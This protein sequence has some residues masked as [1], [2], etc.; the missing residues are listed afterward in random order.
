MLDEGTDAFAE[1]EDKIVREGGWS[2]FITRSK[3]MRSRP[4]NLRTI[5]YWLVTAG[6]QMQW[7]ILSH[8]TVILG[9]SKM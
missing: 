2:L 9:F 6:S 4:M 5:R 1:I 8:R 3:K 7:R